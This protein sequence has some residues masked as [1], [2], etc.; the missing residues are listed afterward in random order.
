VKRGEVEI[1][2]NP[3]E[4]EKLVKILKLRMEGYTD[5]RIGKELDMAPISVKRRIEHIE[6]DYPRIVRFLRKIQR[7][8][9]FQKIG[10][11]ALPEKRQ[12]AQSMIKQKLSEGVPLAVGNVSV[13]PPL[14]YKRVRNV[15]KIDE[16][17]LPL[18]KEIF[19]TYY[20]GGNMSQLCRNHS[21]KPNNIR[22]TMYNPIYIG[23]IIYK[24]TEYYFPHLHKIDREIWEMCQQYERPTRF[25]AVK[26][27]F[28]FVRRA[29]RL[30]KDPEKAST[31]K[32][33]V[34]MRL[35]GKKVCDIAR[36]TRLSSHI[37][38]GVL[39]NPKYCNKL[40]INGKYIDAGIDEIVP[41]EKWLKAHE[42]VSDVHKNRRRIFTFLEE[43]KPRA[44]TYKDLMRELG[45]SRSIVKYNLNTLREDR[46]VD[47]I[48]P[49]KRR[50]G[51][52]PFPYKWRV[53]QDKSSSRK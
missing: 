37:I 11:F 5:Y 20:N 29:G 50:K 1:R 46:L 4:T 25:M 23:K 32:K 22:R 26:A 42:V 15:V 44:F 41:F 38:R 9:Y 45:L 30:F 13:R 10:G 35:M 33:V 12:H 40:L 27:L 52:V 34:D 21:L 3:D 7:V 53:K 8:R 43:N 18:A 6:R 51:A 14:G 17:K 47:R 48:S 24:G 28:G 36:A 16:K 2:I 19:D 49:D 31:V 39:N